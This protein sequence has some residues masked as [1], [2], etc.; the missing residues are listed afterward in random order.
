MARPKVDMSAHSALSEQVAVFAKENGIKKDRA[1]A[2]LVILGLEHK[3][4]FE[5]TR[6]RERSGEFDPA[7]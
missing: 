7:Y 2:E 3:D 6:Q 1:W 5:D 4:E